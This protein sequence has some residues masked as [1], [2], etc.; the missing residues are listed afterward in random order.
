MTGRTGALVAFVLLGAALVAT[1]ALTTPWHPLGAVPGGGVDP[2]VAGDFTAAEVARADAY[3]A[4]VRPPAYAGLAAGLAVALVLGLTPLGARLVDAVA[5]PLPG[6][7]WA[8]VV[9][10]TVAVSLAT[11]VVSLPFDART[12]ALA[13][14]YGLSTR[15]WAGWAGDLA[16][17]WALSTVLLVV[18]LLVLL[19]LMRR[20]PHG[21]WLPAAAGGAVLVLGV[22]FA[23]PLVVEPVFNRFTSMPQSQLRS[24]LLEL[25]RSDGVPARDVLVADASKRTS[26]LNAYVSGYGATRRIVVYD[27]LLEQATPD[28]VTLVVAHELGHAKR[29]DVLYGTAIGALGLATGVC[30]LFLV[31]GWAPLLR[32]AGVASTDDPRVLALVLAVV[33]VVSILSGPVQAVVSRRIEARADLHALDLTRD[34]TAFAQ[35]QRRLAVTNLS[36]LTPPP[37]AF[38]LFASHPSAPMRVAMART[39]ARVHDVPVPG[40]LAQESGPLSPDSARVSPG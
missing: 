10:G 11:R 38:A 27:T 32:R 13:R 34:P 24:D 4:G 31:L 35:M 39:W 30:L 17:G 12:E 14:R 19:F 36:D 40:P 16:K 8:K 5:A 33:A 3:R 2:R 21:W 15:S 20:L 25:A 22:S 26:A 18:V 37:V 23:Y 29:G 1:I 28:E 9:L 7:W 6:S